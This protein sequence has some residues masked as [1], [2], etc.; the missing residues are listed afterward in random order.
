MVLSSALSIDEEDTDAELFNPRYIGIIC[1]RILERLYQRIRENDKV[2]ISA[3]LADYKEWAES[4]FNE[5]VHSQTDF[6]GPLAAPLS[7]RL[8][9]QFKSVDFVLT[10]DAE[11]LDG[12]TPYLM[13]G[14]LQHRSGDI[15]Y[16]GLVD[17]IA[18]QEAEGRAVILDYKTGKVPSATDYTS[19]AMRDFQ[20][21]MYIFLAENRLKQE[22]FHAF[23]RYY[24]RREKVHRQR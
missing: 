5:T 6:R 20:M 13:E 10:F 3:H 23:S 15:L 14:E 7:N 18:Y 17:R 24:E 2:F 1:H 22:V 9:A 4:I 11:K 16:H 19:G 12:Y 8:K 21:P